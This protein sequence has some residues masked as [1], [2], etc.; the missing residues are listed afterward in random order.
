MTEPSA[1][2]LEQARTMLGFALAAAKPHIVQNEM[3]LHWR[4]LR[5]QIAL[6]LDAVYRRGIEDAGQSS[7]PKPAT[8]AVDDEGDRQMLLLAIAELA[9]RRPGWDWTLG[10]LA[11]RLSG[12]EMFDSF[13]QSSARVPPQEGS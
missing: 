5:Q 11:E 7:W 6:A 9:L 3:L 1:E 2:A 10:R 8:D 13:K 4:V 12:R